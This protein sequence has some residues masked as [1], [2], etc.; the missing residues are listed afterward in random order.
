MTTFCSSK[1]SCFCVASGS[2]DW[3]EVE[4]ANRMGS[5]WRGGVPTS[6]RDEPVG[7]PH[8]GHFPAFRGTRHR[9]QSTSVMLAQGFQSVAYHLH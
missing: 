8:L 6:A 3:L 1:D 4:A 2:S 5:G 9:E 7:V